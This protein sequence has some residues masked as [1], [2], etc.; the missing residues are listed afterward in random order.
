MSGHS[1][2]ARVLYLKTFFWQLNL[3]RFRYLAA[4]PLL[5]VGAFF[6]RES[7]SAPAAPLVTKQAK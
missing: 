2:R 5:V 1:R 3:I 4:F 7:A 6:Q